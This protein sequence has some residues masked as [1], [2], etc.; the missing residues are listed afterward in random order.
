[1]TV[2]SS[3]GK[4][5]RSCHKS[6]KI[7]FFLQGPEND[8]GKGRDWIKGECRCIARMHS[9]KEELAIKKEWHELQFP[10]N[11]INPS[12]LL[13][14]CYTYPRI[15]KISRSSQRNEELVKNF[16]RTS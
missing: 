16:L 10:G 9:W 1:M 8:E 2:T 12:R 4:P 11:S 5:S 7:Y 14:G 13:R 3:R 15:L 6:G